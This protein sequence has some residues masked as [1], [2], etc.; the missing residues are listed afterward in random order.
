MSEKEA[1]YK[2]PEEIWSGAVCLYDAARRSVNIG[3]SSGCGVGEG[4]L[5]ALLAD[6]RLTPD[7]LAGKGSPE[8]R[9]YLCLGEPTRRLLR[10]IAIFVGDS[11]EGGMESMGYFTEG[12]K[13]Y[14]HCTPLGHARI[15]ILWERYGQEI[16]RHME[17]AWDSFLEANNLYAPLEGEA[18][19][20]LSDYE[21]GELKKALACWARKAEDGD[22]EQG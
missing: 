3:K 19:F 12:E 1:E 10:M 18:A 14:L 6:C 17:K 13:V 5:L 16:N 15:N 8:W 4:F 2:I 21:K 11:G 7:D 22:Q 20:K 9:P